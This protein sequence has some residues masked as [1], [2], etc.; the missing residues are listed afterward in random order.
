MYQTEDTSLQV[1]KAWH[2]KMLRNSSAHQITE[3]RVVGYPSL[4]YAVKTSRR[5]QKRLKYTNEWIN[6]ISARCVIPRK[7]VTNPIESC[8]FYKKDSIKNK[9]N[10]YNF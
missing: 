2:L 9:Q 8:K 4:E 7:S 10:Q 3:S 5:D 1:I 6:E